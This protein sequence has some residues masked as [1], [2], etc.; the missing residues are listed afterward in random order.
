[1]KANC[2]YTRDVDLRKIAEYIIFTSCYFFHCNVVFI[3]VNRS[4]HVRL[5]Q[6]TIRLLLRNIER[7][8]A[9]WNKRNSKSLGGQ[10][11]VLE[12][13]PIIAFDVVVETFILGACIFVR[14]D[15]RRIAIWI[16]LFT[17]L[18]VKILTMILFKV[19]VNDLNISVR[20]SFGRRFSFRASE[21]TEVTFCMARG[22]YSLKYGLITIKTANRVLDIN[23]TMNGFRP[24]AEYILERLERGE[25]NETAASSDFK[26]GVSDFLAGKLGARRFAP[27]AC[28]TGT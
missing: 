20:T 14:E 18:N 7:E 16:V 12:L 13:V 3:F 24:M 25:I 23:Q 27:A 19:Q 5:R 4:C 17:L 28:E 22:R 1:M 8:S 15:V 26:S 6:L 10:Y 9:E 21:I 2:I 11:N